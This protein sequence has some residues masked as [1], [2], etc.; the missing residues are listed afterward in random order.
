M[1]MNGTTTGFPLLTLHPL[2]Q[3]SKDPVLKMDR[4]HAAIWLLLTKSIF[5][6]AKTMSFYSPI[7]L[8]NPG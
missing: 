6:K 2:T 4:K 7:K 8:Y 5:E 3:R 1:S